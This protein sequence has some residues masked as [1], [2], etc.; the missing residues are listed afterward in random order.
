MLTFDRKIGFTRRD[1]HPAGM[2]I[3]RTAERT[4]LAPVPVHA[5]RVENA[6]VG[7]CVGFG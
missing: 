5:F 2:N 3:G 1:L 4:R 7:Q 6:V